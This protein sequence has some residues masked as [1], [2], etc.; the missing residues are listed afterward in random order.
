MADVVCVQTMM[1]DGS[2]E[3][4]EDMRDM[5]SWVV[6]RAYKSKIA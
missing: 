5:K 3:R 4:I 2:T 1:N 6:G